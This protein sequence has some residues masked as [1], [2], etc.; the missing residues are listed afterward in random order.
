M[1]SAHEI[2]RMFMKCEMVNRGEHFVIEKN[3]IPIKFSADRFEVDYKGITYSAMLMY[4]A[5]P[6]SD[7]RIGGLLWT[8]TAKYFIIDLSGIRKVNANYLSDAIQ[9]YSKNFPDYNFLA[10]SAKIQY[11]RS[12]T[13]ESEAED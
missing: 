8:N 10:L 5:N 1:L 3:S 11:E 12:E 13:I 4:H 6:K 2:R 9:M 7:K